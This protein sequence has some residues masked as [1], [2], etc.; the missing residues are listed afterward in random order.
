[1][2]TK[3][4]SGISA[5][6]PEKPIRDNKFLIEVGKYFLDISKLTFGGLI[7]SSI[8]GM[9]FDLE[10]LMVYGIAASFF[11]ALFGFTFIRVANE[12]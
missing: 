6:K 12:K 3:N 7:L 10:N 5:K 1:M 4:N 2:S 11:F 9:N 8:V